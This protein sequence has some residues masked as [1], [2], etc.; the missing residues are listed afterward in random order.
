MV[1]LALSSGIYCRL[2]W[3]YTKPILGLKGACDTIRALKKAGA[4]GVLSLCNSAQTR[5][6]Y[7]LF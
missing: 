2:M 4:L 5:T 7:F 3:Y 1:W 6:H